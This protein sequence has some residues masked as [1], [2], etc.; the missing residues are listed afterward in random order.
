MASHVLL[1]Q[2]PGASLKT[3]E[4]GATAPKKLRLRERRFAI[5]AYWVKARSE[6]WMTEEAVARRHLAGGQPNVRL[7]SRNRRRGC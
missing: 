3:K 1:L 6:R 5:M 2:W 7:T 4:R